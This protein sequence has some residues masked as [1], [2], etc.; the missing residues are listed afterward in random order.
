MRTPLLA[1][2]AILVAAAVVYSLA[3]PWLARR[4]LAAAHPKQAHAYDPLSTQAL[5]DWAEFINEHGT[6]AALHRVDTTIA[7]RE[8]A[9]DRNSLLSDKGDDVNH[10]NEK[11]VEIPPK[12]PDKKPI[13]GLDS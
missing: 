12:G 11:I 2:A 6:E 8:A 4:E 7:E 1:A 5:I 9:K 3:A 10:S 13:R